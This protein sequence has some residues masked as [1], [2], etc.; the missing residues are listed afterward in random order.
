MSVSLKGRINK[1]F[2]IGIINKNL[3]EESIESPMTFLS[4]KLS[5]KKTLI[6]FPTFNENDQ[7]KS[8]NTFSTEHPISPFIK[9]NDKIKL[10]SFSSLENIEKNEKNKSQTNLYLNN[11]DNDSELIYQRRRINSEV[12]K[13]SVDKTRLNGNKKSVFGGITEFKFEGV[14]KSDRENLIKI[15]NLSQIII[16]RR[17]VKKNLKSKKSSRSLSVF[18]I[19]SLK[20]S[21][22]KDSNYLDDFRQGKKKNKIRSFNDSN[23]TNPFELKTQTSLPKNNLKFYFTKCCL[24]QF[25]EGWA[26]K[27]TINSCLLYTSPSPRDKRQSRMPSSA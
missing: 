25:L 1:N 26:N 5:N 15:N 13:T 17:D 18:L 23:Q 2:Q 9:V 3:K 27:R 6:K 12:I 22:S 7:M 10:I 4:K 20:K 19:P 16:S 8:L 21:D 24:E 14:Q 11:M